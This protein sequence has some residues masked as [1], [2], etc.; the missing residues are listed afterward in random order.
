LGQS[1]F[2]ISKVG[3]EEYFLATS[4]GKRRGKHLGVYPIF[5]YKLFP[6]LFSSLAFGQQYYWPQHLLYFGHFQTT[7]RTAAV[8]LTSYNLSP[9]F[10]S[11][12]KVKSSREIFTSILISNERLKA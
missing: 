6:G 11:T 1:G 4:A 2:R 12:D 5:A 10:S 7:L 8:G 9:C 3:I